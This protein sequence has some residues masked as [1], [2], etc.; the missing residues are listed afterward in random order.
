MAASARLIVDGCR[1]I[2][3]LPS[4]L[5]SRKTSITW[6]TKVELI[7]ASRR[8]GGEGGRADE[9][10]PQGEVVVVMTVVVVEWLPSP[11]CEWEEEESVW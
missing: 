8:A 6:R 1:A 9:V 4:G 2:L 11:P 3:R 10:A 5:T 7:G